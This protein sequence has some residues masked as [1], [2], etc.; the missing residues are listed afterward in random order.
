MWNA[1]SIQT[2]SASRSL[3]I[4]PNGITRSA[5]SCL[6]ELFNSIQ[7]GE[8]PAFLYHIFN[9]LTILFYVSN[10]QTTTSVGSLMHSLHS[11]L[12]YFPICIAAYTCIYIPVWMYILTCKM[13]ILST[14]QC[15]YIYLKRFVFIIYKFYLSL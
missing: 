15:K 3:Y 2:C 8:H 10:K 7:G 13:E 5:I 1:G 14:L 4:V 9:P 6:R 12:H 11:S